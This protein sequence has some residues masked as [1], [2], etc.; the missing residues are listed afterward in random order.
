MRT[1]R[2][3]GGFYHQSSCLGA[4]NRLGSKESWLPSVPCI[5]VVV[6]LEFYIFFYCVLCACVHVHVAVNYLNLHWASSEW[7]CLAFLPSAQVLWICGMKRH[8]WAVLFL[9]CLTRSMAGPLLN[10]HV[11]NTLP[12]YPRS[13]WGSW[14]LRPLSLLLTCLRFLRLISLPPCCDHS[15]F[16]PLCFLPSHWLLAFYWRIKSQ[17][18]A[19]TCSGCANS[20]VFTNQIPNARAYHHVRVEVRGHLGV[21]CSFHYVGSWW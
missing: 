8:T 16:S 3:F 19:G 6:F 4:Y 18:L 2:C 17:L 7:S 15:A 9:V 11:A 13:G 1:I 14:P 20:H 5:F 21:S 10:L 12:S